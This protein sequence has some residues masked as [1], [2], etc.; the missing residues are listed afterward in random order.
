MTEKLIFSS[1]PHIHT[2][3]TVRGSMLHVIV[4]LLPAIFCSLYFFGFPAFTVLCVSGVV[5]VFTEWFITR[6]MLRRPS[7]VGDFSAVLTVESACQSSAVDGCVRKCRGCRN[8][9]DGL[10][11]S[12]LQHIQPGVG[13]ARLSAYLFSC[14]HD[15]LAIAGC[16]IRRCRRGYGRNSSVACETRPA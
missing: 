8:R 15:M 16:R 7:T 14:R 6:Y 5:C 12:R 9:Q 13:R 3:R 2:S 10:R 4:A 1:S 11:R